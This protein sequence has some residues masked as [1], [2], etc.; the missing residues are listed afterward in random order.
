MSL[1]FDMR[2]N[3]LLMLLSYFALKFL[4]LV[5]LWRSRPMSLLCKP[6]SRLVLRHNFSV[7]FAQIKRNMLLHSLHFRRYYM[8]ETGIYDACR[9][10]HS[11]FVVSALYR[12]DVIQLVLSIYILGNFKVLFAGL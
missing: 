11:F 3:L 9:L 7:F 1:T 10:S 12:S 5:A 6:L 2:V 4:A 8:A